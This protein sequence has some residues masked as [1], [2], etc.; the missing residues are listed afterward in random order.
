MDPA[1]T[2]PPD[3]GEASIVL[4]PLDWLAVTD[5]PTC[6]GDSCT[7][8]VADAALTVSDTAHNQR[9]PKR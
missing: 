9:C 6:I 7:M 1:G 3:P 5:A 8:T 4:Q 2:T